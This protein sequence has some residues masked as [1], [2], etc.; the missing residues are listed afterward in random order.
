MSMSA[1]PR[2]VL[3]LL[4][5]AV[6]AGAASAQNITLT[7]TIQPPASSIPAGTSG[8]LIYQF[9]LQKP[10]NAT[11]NLTGLTF[12]D[13]GT[14]T[15][16]DFT[17]YHLYHVSQTLVET[18]LA[19][20]S[21]P[22]TGFSGFSQVLANN[23]QTAF[24]I[25]VDVTSGAANG[26]TFQLSVA[27]TDVTV[28]AGTVSGGPVNGNTHTISNTGTT[29]VMEVRDSQPA[30]VASGA[31]YDLTGAM[32][33]TP[34]AGQ[35]YNYTIHNVGTGTLNLTGTP[36]VQINGEVNCS[37]GVTQPANT[38]ITNGNPE[39]FSLFI[40]PGTAGTFSFVVAI[41]NNSGA[42]PYFFTV[43][44][45]AVAAAPEMDVQRPAG[46]A[47]SIPDGTTNHDIGTLPA[48]SLTTISW[49]I[50]NTGSADLNLTGSPVVVIG[51]QNNCT[52]VVS[53][54]PSTPVTATGGTTT[55]D[56][57]ITPGA[58]GGAFDFTIS[59]DNDDADENPYNFTVI[60][61]GQVATAT[62]L[63]IA[64]QPGG[65]TG[66]VAWAQQPSVEAH[67]GSGLVTSYTG[68]VVANITAATGTAGATLIGTVSVNCVG[69]VA[70][71]T[72]L[73]IDLAGTGYTLDFTSG[74]L[75]PAT[76]SPFNITVGPAVQLAIQTQPGNGTGGSALS[77]QP[78]VLIQ[79]AGGNTVTTDNS[80][81]VTAS[82]STGTGTTGATVMAGSTA[83]ASA[84]VATF[85][86]LSIDLAGTGY[87]L[88]FD[89]ST[90]T[91]VTSTQFDVTVG[92]AT[93]LRIATQP[94][95]GT[96][97][98]PLVTQPV[99]EIIDA[100]GNVVTSDSTTQVSAAITTGTGAGGALLSGANNPAT[101]SSGVVTFT[102]LEIDLPGTDYRLDFQDVGTAF[103]VVVSDQFDVAGAPSQLAIQLQPGGAV[104]GSQF[105][106]QPVLEV[107]DAV[108]AVVT[109]DNTTQVTVTIS[110]G[111]GA[112]I[113]GSTTTMTAVNGIVTFT[114]LGIDTAGTGFVLQFD[115]TLAA[116]TNV[117]SNPFDVA[118]PATQLVI[119]TQPGGATP[120]TA[121]TQ[122]PVIEIQDAAGVVVSTDNSTQVTVTISAGTGTA[123]ATLGGTTTVTAVNGV[124]TFADLSIDLAGVGYTLDFD[125]GGALTAATS[126]SFDV[127]A[128][129]GGGGGGGGGDD[130]GCSTGTGKSWL[131]LLALL[132]VLGVAAR[133]QRA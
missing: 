132:A 133:R 89:A 81:V 33:N 17:N 112:F 92:P 25:R 104:A 70:D 119:V 36:A 47:N 116:L 48:G 128:G 63:V 113:G 122:Q 5:S 15:A 7:S 106:T 24:V 117:S 69:G 93:A 43:D 111:T 90:F 99:I 53:Q 101:A 18:F 114:D 56:I 44:G 52:A 9:T 37:V 2:L 118:G 57:D 74:A 23:S 64:T 66:G 126:T 125:D 12:T 30:L 40:D 94:G 87:T 39:S 76:S 49:T 38:A 96:Q 51:T 22:G 62:M 123:G 35:T 31:T 10:G 3:L 108:G 42:N 20:T 131:I 120:G 46:S 98:T 129:S 109:S 103:A 11:S 85:A 4:I 77:T 88:D 28:S 124:V 34:L 13:N 71:F 60:G 59:I 14:R 102:D 32:G 73:A 78:E 67:D 29:P 107:Q 127:T 105:V 95:N 21:S 58:G 86:G 83:T 72:D 41:L 54:N 130:E 19:S 68:A 16:G 82:I 61:T 8:A 80:T 121:F 110:V 55:F 115:D 91:T 26:N 79:D 75:T 6:A 1:L 45:D 50:E 100:G 65:G 97:A 27:S 84:G